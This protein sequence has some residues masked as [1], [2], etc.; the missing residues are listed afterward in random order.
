MIDGMEN[1]NAEN[2]LVITGKPTVAKAANAE[3]ESQVQ[4]VM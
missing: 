3:R 2:L 1:S 4:K